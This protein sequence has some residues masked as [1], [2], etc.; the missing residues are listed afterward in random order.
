MSTLC[1][2]CA[3]HPENE[4]ARAGSCK[5]GKRGRP[6]KRNNNPKAKINVK[7]EEAP[8][9]GIRL[10]R[11]HWQVH[12]AKLKSTFAASALLFCGLESNTKA[13]CWGCEKRCLSWMKVNHNAEWKLHNEAKAGDN[14]PSVACILL[15][16]SH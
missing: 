5:S 16:Y 4:G 6:K 2:A 15:L 8:L 13:I 9:A 3:C 12:S 11:P 14:F 10:D 7:D 1:C